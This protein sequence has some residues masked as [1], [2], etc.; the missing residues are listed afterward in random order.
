MDNLGVEDEQKVV[1]IC[2]KHK[3][4]IGNM[5]CIDLKYDQNRYLCKKCELEGHERHHYVNELKNSDI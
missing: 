2:E 5:V 3:E 4:K 1:E